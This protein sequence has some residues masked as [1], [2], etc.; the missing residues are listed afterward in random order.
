MH[1]HH[2][3]SIHKTNI[4]APL[5]T[6]RHG[7]VFRLSSYYQKENSSLMVTKR[8]S[9]SWRIHVRFFF[10]ISRSYGTDLW[11][12]HHSDTNTC[13]LVLCFIFQTES[14]SICTFCRIFVL[15]GCRLIAKGIAFLGRSLLATLRNMDNSSDHVVFANVSIPPVT[16]SSS[17]GFARKSYT[18]IWSILK[19]KQLA[20]I[21]AGLVGW[22][23][24]LQKQLVY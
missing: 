24:F 4:Y 9:F 13:S 8:F 6:K 14:E 15:K 19:A 7:H 1:R 17:V 22:N 5:H 2:V 3:G 16:K 20:L 21:R 23:N 10:T 18:C 11:G 12:Q